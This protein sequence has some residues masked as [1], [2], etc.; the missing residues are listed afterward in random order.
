L[1]EGSGKEVI[2]VKEGPYR[3]ERMLLTEG[4]AS[5]KVLR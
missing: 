4:T 3:D 1:R 5:T 2:E